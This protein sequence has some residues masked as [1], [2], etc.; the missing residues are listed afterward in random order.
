MLYGSKDE[1]ATHW[2]NL[3]CMARTEERH[4]TRARAFDFITQFL[5]YLTCTPRC[6]PYEHFISIKASLVLAAHSLL[7]SFTRLN[8]FY[9]F[10]FHSPL[11]RFYQVNYS[12]LLWRALANASASSLAISPVDYAGWTMASFCPFQIPVVLSPLTR[13]LFNYHTFS[14]THNLFK[15]QSYFLH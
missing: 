1:R 8:R 9:F 2:Q 15:Y 3:I 7:H 11:H 10:S 5:K 12:V 14:T 6:K 4:N 13:L